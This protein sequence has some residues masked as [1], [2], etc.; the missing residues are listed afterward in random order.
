MTPIEIAALLALVGY[1]VYR[2]SRQY[3]AI[4]KTRFKLAII[5]AVVGLVVGGFHRP[6]TRTEVLL[7]LASL[8]LSILVGLAR[9]RLTKIWVGADGRTYAR[10]TAVTIALF[11]GLVLV[12]FGLGTAAYFAG[13]S[14]DGGFGEVMLMIA[15]MV[16]FQAEIVWRRALALTGQV[17]PSPRVVQQG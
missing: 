17:P 3:E 16:A 13:V 11:L 5:Y 4:G 10:G 12:K 1:A 8:A 6:D 2:Q 15:A 7:L 14:N 9:G